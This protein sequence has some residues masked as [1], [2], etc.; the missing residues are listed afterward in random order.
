MHRTEPVPS[1]A[2]PT[3]GASPPDATGHDGSAAATAD[4]ADA[5]WY[6][7]G[8]AEGQQLAP[9]SDGQ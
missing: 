3:T 9:N 5:E 7:H 8:H 4:D 6:E 2:K 1:P